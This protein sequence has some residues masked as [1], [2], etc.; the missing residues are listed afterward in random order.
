MEEKPTA[1]TVENEVKAKVTKQPQP[2][3]IDKP[4]S[5]KVEEKLVIN[6]GYKANLKILLERSETPEPPDKRDVDKNVLMPTDGALINN[7][8]P[9]SA[10]SYTFGNRPYSPINLDGPTW[11]RSR[12]NS[13]TPTVGPQRNLSAGYSR[14]YLT[15]RSRLPPVRP[16]SPHE[17]RNASELADLYDK[18]TIAC[19]EK[20][21]KEKQEKVGDVEDVEEKLKGEREGREEGKV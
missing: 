9:S 4:K 3:V 18:I 12:P 11:L 7:L 13:A 5:P 20:E 16:R 6:E 2:P 1:V 14:P 21:K 10:Y 8:R 15:D 17:I 19:E